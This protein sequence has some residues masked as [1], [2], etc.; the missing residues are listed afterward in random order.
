MKNMRKFWLVK[1]HNY[2]KINKLL[3]T[4][5]YQNTI[6]EYFK[7]YPHVYIGINNSSNGYMPP[8]YLRPCEIGQH[9]SKYW[10]INENYQY[11]GELQ[12]K[13][14]T[15]KLKLLKINTIKDEI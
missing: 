3:E 10:F 11:Q 9:D 4:N 7:K 15:R 12:T 6:D 8:T 2:N 1:Y 5:F 13:K 14:E